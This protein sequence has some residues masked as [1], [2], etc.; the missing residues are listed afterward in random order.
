MNIGDTVRVL[1]NRR[2]SMTTGGQVGK[3]IFINSLSAEVLW[4]EETS[5]S[6]GI[7]INSLYGWGI[8]LVYLELV[9]AI[10]PQT[11]EQKVA[12]RCKKLWNTSNWVKKNPHLA[13]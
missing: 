1:R 4:N 12:T 2:Y 8:E 11:T 5:D 3:I 6:L 7:P 13:Y 9:E 10:P